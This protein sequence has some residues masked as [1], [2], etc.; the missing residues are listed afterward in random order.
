[1]AHPTTQ[2]SNFV[3]FLKILKNQKGGKVEPF[4]L[5]DFMGYVACQ[6]LQNT[7]RQKILMLKNS[8]IVSADE[9]WPRD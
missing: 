3:E 8:K 7:T 9:N 5:F 2:I 1:M 6:I 4:F